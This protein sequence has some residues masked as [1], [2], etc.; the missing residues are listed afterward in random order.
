M[1]RGLSPPSYGYCG[2]FGSGVRG[3]TLSES[4][5][6][7]QFGK[8]YFG[9]WDLLCVSGGLMGVRSDF[10]FKLRTCVPTGLIGVWLIILCVV[11]LRV[12]PSAGRVLRQPFDRSIH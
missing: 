1:V 9:K 11:S 3:P 6:H 5:G 12:L 2:Y 10:Y 7:P 8:C 4:I